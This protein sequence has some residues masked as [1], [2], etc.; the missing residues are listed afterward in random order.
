M[1]ATL[2][3]YWRGRANDIRSGIANARLEIA[4]A[5]LAKDRARI[6]RYVDRLGQY[7]RDLAVLKREG[8]TK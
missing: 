8:W 1:T 5:K 7:R 2:T 3:D 4:K 6:D